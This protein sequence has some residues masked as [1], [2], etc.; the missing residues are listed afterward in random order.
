MHINV[1]G[2]SFDISA[3]EAGGL[4]AG[5]MAFIATMWLF[6]LV[7]MVIMIIGMWKVFEKAGREGWKSLIPFYNMYVLTE[8]SGQNGWLFLLCLIPGVG[9][10]IWSIMVSI[11]L[12]P[13]FGKETAFAVGLILL[14]PIF[15]MILGFGNA[16]YVLGSAPASAKSGE[17]K[18]PK[19][20][21][22]A[23]K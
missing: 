22:I 23:G 3:G 19:D 20:P 5:L 14:A 6:A 10:L 18:A 8:I 16:K 7:V 12:A 13:A 9:S 17:P 21:W 4:F 2:N 15:Y 11:K 1:D